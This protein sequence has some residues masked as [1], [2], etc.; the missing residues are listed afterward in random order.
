MRKLEFAIYKCN[1]KLSGSC[2]AGFM[3]IFCNAGLPESCHAEARGISR[4]REFENTNE[5][6]K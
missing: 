1:I 5:L 6:I 4:L 2:H 3:E